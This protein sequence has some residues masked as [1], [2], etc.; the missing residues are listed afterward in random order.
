MVSKTYSLLGTAE[1]LSQQLLVSCVYTR[2]KITVNLYH[3]VIPVF[4]HHS[5]V[6]C[7]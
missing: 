2:Q 5:L 6:L 4:P 1:F 3:S 7:I